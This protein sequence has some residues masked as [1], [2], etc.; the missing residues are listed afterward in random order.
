MAHYKAY[1]VA[2]GDR[3]LLGQVAG[4]AHIEVCQNARYMAVHQLIGYFLR[5]G[6]KGLR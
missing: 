1:A 4:L 2:S 6:D 5:S 3:V